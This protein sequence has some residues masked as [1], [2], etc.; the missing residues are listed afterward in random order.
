MLV[1]RICER[2]HAYKGT[3]ITCIGGWPN[4]RVGL[5]YFVLYYQYL[6]V[7]HEANKAQIRYGS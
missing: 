6:V 1:K 7:A 4:D 5:L 3:T 2:I